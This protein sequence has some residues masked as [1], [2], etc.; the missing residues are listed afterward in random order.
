M[1]I[2]FEQSMHPVDGPFSTYHVPA[3]APADVVFH[4]QSSNDLQ[5]WTNEATRIA[6]GP[7]EGPGQVEAAQS[8]E[9]LGMV[10][11]KHPDI[12]TAFTRLKV[13]VVNSPP[14]GPQ[15]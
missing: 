1:P 8:G 11:I 10:R 4:I 6:N 3:V 13:E 12:P 14:P 5:T 7:W 15:E 2:L 9:G